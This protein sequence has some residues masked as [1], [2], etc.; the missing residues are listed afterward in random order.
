MS[1]KHILI[2]HISV[3]AVAAY[4]TNIRRQNCRGENSAGRGVRL[5]SATLTDLP[6]RGSLESLEELE[7]LW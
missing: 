1:K 2:N 7:Q 4:F 3:G 6:P 5:Y